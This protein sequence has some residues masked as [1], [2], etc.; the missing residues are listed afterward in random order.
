MKNPL[1]QF[2]ILTFLVVALLHLPSVAAPTQT[3]TTEL[4]T[5]KAILESR[6]ASPNQ[7][8]EA[9]EKLTLLIAKNSNLAQAY[10]YRGEIYE[11]LNK[12]TES[13]EDFNKAI[14]VDPKLGRAYLD[15]GLSMFFKNDFKAAISDFDKAIENGEKTEIAYQNRGAGY[16]QLGQHEKAIEDFTIAINNKPIWPSYMMRATSYAATNQMDLAIKD[17]DSALSV[18]NLPARAKADAYERRG[19][20]RAKTD[21]FKEAI[22]DFTAAFD[23]SAEEEKGRMIYLRSLA[24]FKLGDKNAAEADQKLAKSLGYPKDG[25][26]DKPISVSTTERL[27]RLEE[28]IKPL[29]E[30]ARKT[31]PSAKA[32]YLKG[33]PIGHRFYV[34]AKIGDSTN[35]FEQVFV[36]VSGWSGTTITGTLSSQVRLQGYKEGDTL[37]LDESNIL[38]WTISKPDG[39]EEGNLIGKFL[40]NWKG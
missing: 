6:G 25:P 16:Q 38:D 24:N 19:Y 11:R 8:L 17:F 40:D 23:C 3:E 27:S 7:L 4:A 26:Q 32:K 22:A 28:A 30:E 18:K 21:R 35:H 39:T 15:R 36:S 10:C 14:E 29:I 20:V 31:L 34:T 1:R 9:A 12:T 2:S 5:A 33:L 13:F 37:K